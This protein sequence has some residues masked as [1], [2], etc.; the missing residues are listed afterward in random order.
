MSATLSHHRL[1]ISGMSCAG[2]VA[3]VENALKSVPGVQAATVNFAEHTANV[4]GSA[5]ANQLIK[6]VVDA[7]YDAAELQSAADEAQKQAI[8]QSHYKKLLLKALV[9]AIVAIPLLASSVLGAMPAVEGAG[10][11]FWAAISVISLFVLVFSGRQF[12]VGAWKTFRAHNANMDT[13]IALGTGTAWIYSTAI[14]IYPNLVPPLARHVYF[15]AAV[16]IIG[17]INF[18]SALE[19]RARGKTSEAIQRLIGL[20]PKTARVIRDGKESD[21]AIEQVGLDET[22]RVR[23]G[24]KIP[25]DGVII[26]GHSTVDESMLT[27]EPMAAAKTLGSE[28]VGGTINKSGSFLYLAK[29]VGK[30]TTLAQIIEMVRRAQNTKPA[31]GRLAD[32]IAA[33]FVPTVLIIAVI[34]CLAWY[35]FGPEPKASFV[36][37]STV[38][39]LIIAC[40]CALGLA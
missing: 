8:E 19:M 37:V 31:I 21:I 22:I 25:V 33:V 16:I 38:T 26:E 34:T 10:R 30:D 40:P 3:T 15:E 14:V 12:F 29:R 6:A 35:N 32:R 39:V 7:G 5:A 18:G 1:S 28:V 20:Q 23:P 27:G 17:L 36:L 9:A 24:E 2:C 13:L 4:E 11:W